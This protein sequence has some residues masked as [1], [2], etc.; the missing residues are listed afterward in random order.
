MIALKNED[1]QKEHV[2]LCADHLLQN[3]AR[4][5]DFQASNQK[6]ANI[7]Y[8]TFSSHLKEARSTANKAEDEKKVEVIPDVQDR[9][10]LTM[11]RFPMEKG[12]LCWLSTLQEP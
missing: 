6:Y 7:Q 5:D 10:V 12:D 4:I 2:I 3:K 1:Y 9:P 8:Y 11:Q